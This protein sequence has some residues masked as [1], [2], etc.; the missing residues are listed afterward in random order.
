MFYFLI[1]TTLLTLILAGCGGNEDDV[2]TKNNTVNDPN[3]EKAGKGET[4]NQFKEITTFELE[5]PVTNLNFNLDE[6]GDTLFWGE[7]DG[8]FGDDL[9][10]NVWVDG[11]VKTL[12][13][14]MFGQA[15][16]LNGAGYIINIENNPEATS[17]ERYSI[18]EYNPSTEEIEKFPTKNGFDDILLPNQG[19]YLQDPRTYIHTDTN[20]NRE[21][22]NGTYIW[23]VESNEFIEVSFIDDIK[24]EVGELSGYVHLYLNQDASIVYGSVQGE[25][26]F[27]YDVASGTTE[28]LLTS[29]NLLPQSRMSPVLTADEKYIIYGEVDP[30][31]SEIIYAYHALNLETGETIEIGDG[32]KVVTLTDGNAVIIYDNEV[33]LFDFATEKLETIHTIEL[34]ENQEIDNLT[35]SLD[36]STIAY[37]YETKAEDKA[38]QMSILSNN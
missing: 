4:T 10:R 7:N 29:E 32:E 23:K 16:H 33:M 8:G 20:P 18:I 34:E 13:I 35:V 37:G 27:S 22:E 30:E 12:D 31:A 14:K 1:V 3:E 2:S 21:K 17:G 6:D 19:T 38:Y 36:G 24:E 5:G 15:S 25:G 9:R 26:I 28:R 11:G